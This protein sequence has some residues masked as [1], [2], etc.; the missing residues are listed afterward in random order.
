MSNERTP[1][2]FLHD[3]VQE[4]VRLDSRVE[5]NYVTGWVCVAESI[6]PTGKR[7]LTRMSSSDGE[8]ELPAW[9]RAGLLHDALFAPWET[10]D[11][12]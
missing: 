11:T 3:A 9:T 8:E 6:A 10:A 5:G 2:A 4:A 1:V 12:D 7:W